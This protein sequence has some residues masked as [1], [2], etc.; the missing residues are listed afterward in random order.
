MEEAVALIELG[1]SHDECLYAQIKFLQAYGIPVQLVV[2]DELFERRLDRR[3][4]A[5]RVEVFPA[6]RNRVTEWSLNAKVIKFLKGRGIRQAI[7]NTAHGKGARTLCTL[8]PRSLELFGIAH[9]ARRLLNWSVT[10]S[11]ISRR[12]KQYFVLSDYIADNLRSRR[13]KRAVSSFY[14][15]YFPMPEE[16]VDSGGRFWIAIP[17]KPEFKRR[18][19]LGLIA[20]LGRSKLASSVQFVVLGN[21][22]AGNGPEVRRR[23]AEAGLDESFV[24]F[25]RFVDYSTM[26][27]CLGAC[28]AVLPL[29][30]PATDGF[31]N[32]LRY[33][34]TGAF[35]LARAVG[36]PML[37]HERF[38]E[39]DEFRSDAMFYRE[40]T[41]IGSIDRMASNP[42]ELTRLAHNASTC[43]RFKFEN[44]ARQFVGCLRP[45]SLAPR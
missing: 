39:C 44:Q 14:P 23:V 5:E 28:Q 2:S 30:H 19:Y 16:A 32:Y 26:L 7:L 40:E 13:L 34:I 41:L 8:A 15:I 33:Q 27:G 4:G 45:E 35:S 18:D 36:R 43:E 3:H 11:L 38:A 31:E 37:L 6:A 20:A 21:S 17:G 25:D 12:I 9:N 1:G 10:Q 42:G 22:T 29:L 24:W